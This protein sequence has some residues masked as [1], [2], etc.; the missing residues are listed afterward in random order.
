MS[1]G[2]LDKHKSIVLKLF[3]PTAIRSMVTYGDEMAVMAGLVAVA[4]SPF[5]YGALVVHRMASV[6]SVRG[7]AV[8]FAVVLGGEL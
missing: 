6:W 7:F 5:P 8:W 2:P 1:S 4:V 3:E